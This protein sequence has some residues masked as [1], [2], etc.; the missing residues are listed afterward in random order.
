MIRHQP[1]ILAPLRSA[2]LFLTFGLSAGVD[3]VP[4]LG[5]LGAMAWS[6]GLT[7]GLGAPL[8]ASLGH[9]VEGLDVFA[10]RASRAVTCP[11]TQGALF[12]SLAGDDPGALLLRARTLVALLGPAFR[13][14]DEVA[15]FK[16]RTGHDLT[17][18]EDGTENP[19]GDNA[20]K[21][22]II[23]GR[24]PGV[25]GGSFVAVQKYVHD[26][27]RFEQM[28]QTTRDHAIGRHH[29]SNAELADAPESAHVKRAAQESFEPNAFMVRKS[30]AWGSS[31]EHGL[32]FVAFGASLDPFDRVL[33]RMM[34]MDDGVTDALFE[35]TRPVTGANYFCPPL[36]GDKLDLTSIGIR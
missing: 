24:G 12:L 11:S 1:D 32:V 7:L 36:H 25:D 33:A 26:L 16:H 15:A 10:A 31:R 34:G 27:A 17:G 29:E 28:S 4:G 2:G 21:A 30:L 14:D 20:R 9:H 3:P 22:A 19:H 13:L 8:V 23:A 35:F 18:Y 5:R 6:E